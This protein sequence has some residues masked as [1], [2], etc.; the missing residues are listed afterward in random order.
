MCLL[1][2]PLSSPPSGSDDHAR[3]DACGQSEILE[4]LVR[5]EEVA[6]VELLDRSVQ[7]VETGRQL[8]RRED[9]KIPHRFGHYASVISIDVPLASGAAIVTSNPH[10]NV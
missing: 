10:M 7:L 4:R 5:F 8:V 1:A 3:S 9:R 2:L 6:V